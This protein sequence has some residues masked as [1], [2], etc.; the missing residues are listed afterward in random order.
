MQVLVQKLVDWPGVIWENG[1]RVPHTCAELFVNQRVGSG[2]TRW[3]PA[4]LTSA[5]VLRWHHQRDASF[6]VVQ[7]W[8]ERR[9][10]A[11][12]EGFPG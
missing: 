11:H 12:F 5:A 9:A 10:L 2:M 3:A 4:Y 1:G 7:G 6:L 8:D